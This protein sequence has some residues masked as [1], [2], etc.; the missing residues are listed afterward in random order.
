[1]EADVG[2]AR[3][4]RRPF[5]L[6]F[7]H[8]VFGKVA[9]AGRD[10]LLDLLRRPTLAHRHQLNLR[11]ISPG[12]IRRDGNAVEDVLAAGNGAGRQNLKAVPT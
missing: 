4:D 1:M 6:G 2:V 3:K 12:T 10:D 8:L 5:R 7:L 11:G 9:L